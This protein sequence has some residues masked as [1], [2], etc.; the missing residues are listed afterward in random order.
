MSHN[1]LFKKKIA[2]DRRLVIL[3]FL[4]EENDGMMSASLMQDALELMAHKVPRATVLDDA[5]FLEGL[6]L[7]RLEYAG[8]VPLLRLT[9]KGQEVAQ[10]VITVE[11]V[12]HPR[13]GE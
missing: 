3:R 9:C 4:N 12:K 2:E 5:A 6:G 8:T 10:G 11:G 13:R 7:L 1:E